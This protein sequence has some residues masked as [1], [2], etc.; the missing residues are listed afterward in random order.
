MMGTVCIYGNGG[1]GAVVRGCVWWFLGSSE[2]LRMGD[3]RK[4]QLG[5]QGDDNGRVEDLERQRDIDP[6]ISAK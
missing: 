1:A 6:G 5:V 4:V 2:Y 3:L